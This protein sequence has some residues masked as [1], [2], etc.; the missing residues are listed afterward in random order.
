MR[1]KNLATSSPVAGSRRRRGLFSS[2]ALS[3]LAA[4]TLAVLVA[5][6]AGCS[7]S[8]PPVGGGGKAIQPPPPAITTDRGVIFNVTITGQG[9]QILVDKL[10]IEFNRRRGIHELYGFF[11]DSYTEM[12]R[13]PFAEIKRIDF[14]GGMPQSAFEQAIIG[15]E[16]Q[17]LLPQQAFEVQLTYRDD[18]KKSF[19][20]FIAMFRGEK[21]LVLW[22]F[23]M[24][25]RSNSILFIE[26]DR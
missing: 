6:G 23:G 19:Y 26:F 25:S 17:N 10:E 11:L 18:S 22:E 5:V 15:R 2:R 7:S 1:T 20:A 8:A 4:G 14:R 24:D 21:D 9:G 16:D 12:V 3:M 13:I